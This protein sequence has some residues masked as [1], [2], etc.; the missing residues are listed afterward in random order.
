MSTITFRTAQ[1]S[2]HRVVDPAYVRR[3]VGEWPH[4]TV[5]RSIARKNNWH[6]VRVRNAGEERGADGALLSTRYEADYEARNERGIRVLIVLPAG[7]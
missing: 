1:A 2:P 4:E 3:R 6:F 5:A 7:G